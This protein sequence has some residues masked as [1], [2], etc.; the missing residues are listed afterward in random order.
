MMKYLDL[1]STPPN[2]HVTDVPEF[3]EEVASVQC[4]DHGYTIRDRTEAEPVEG[5]TRLDGHKQPRSEEQRQHDREGN[6]KDMNGF[7]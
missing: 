5:L 4:E 1:I 6:E 2:L 3:S 7:E